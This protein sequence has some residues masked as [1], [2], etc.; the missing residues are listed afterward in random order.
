MQS[1][2]NKIIIFCSL[3]ECFWSIVSL[4]S[5]LSGCSCGLCCRHLFFFFIL[6]ALS[7]LVFILLPIDCLVRSLYVPED[8]VHVVAP[9]DARVGHAIVDLCCLT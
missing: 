5:L 1:A 7:K 4:L 2:C 9:L 8:V 3:K 6:F